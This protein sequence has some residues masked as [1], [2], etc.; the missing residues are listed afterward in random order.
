MPHLFFMMTTVSLSLHGHLWHDAFLPLTKMFNLYGYIWIWRVHHLTK[1]SAFFI[2]YFCMW[3]SNIQQH[4][5]E[6]CLT[7]PI[8]MWNQQKGTW[9]WIMYWEFCLTLSAWS[10]Y[11][12]DLRKLCNFLWYIGS[13]HNYIYIIIYISNISYFGSQESFGNMIKTVLAFADKFNRKMLVKKELKN[14]ANSVV[15]FRNKWLVEACSL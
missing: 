6:N 4:I 11:L 7:F 5:N 2:F 15:L 1:L 9:P 14:S 8:Q 10:I 12:L 3:S 13:L